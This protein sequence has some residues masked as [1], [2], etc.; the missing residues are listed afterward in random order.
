MFA[1]LPQLAHGGVK[2]LNL[3]SFYKPLLDRTDFRVQLALAMSLLCFLIVATLAIGASVV[4]EREARGATSEGLVGLAA[5]LADRLARGADQRAGMVEVLARIE[6][7]KPVLA[8]DPPAAR[9]LLEQTL[10]SIQGG[11]WF[12]FASADGTVTVAAEGSRE[13]FSAG[14]RSW[15]EH[16]LQGTIV[17]QADELSYSLSGLAPDGEPYPIID[18][19]SPVRDA[20]GKPV[21]V[22]AFSLNWLWAANLRQQTLN[23]SSQWQT[24]EL[25]I[26]SRDGRMIVGPSIGS[27]PYSDAVLA[28]MLDQN[29]GSFSD[30]SKKDRMLT[31]FAVMQDRPSLGW[32]VIARQPEAIA[33]A[34]AH[35]VV[36]VI[37][38]LGLLT[39]ML[40]IVASLYLANRVSQPIMKLAHEADL[41]ERHS[42]EMLPRVRGS[43]EVVRLSSAL[44]ALILRIGFAEERTAAAELRAADAATRLSDDI[45]RLRNLADTDTLTKLLNRRRFLDLAYEAMDGFRETG[46]GFGILMIDVDRFKS[47]NDRFGHPAGDRA[48]QWVAAKIIGS[49]RPNDLAARFGGEEFIVLVA[50]ISMEGAEELAERIRLSI[51]SE[52][53]T[54]VGDDLQITVSIGVALTEKSDVDVE[55]LIGRADLGLYRAKATGRN[56]V[57]AVAGGTPARRV[58]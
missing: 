58:A 24:K 44:R 1:R 21:G 3:G 12:R 20:N 36:S 41:I 32:I 47:V 40:G 54:G 2:V 49:V 43:R 18:L 5:T 35:H 27:K 4:G 14:G 50:E 15:F 16:G 33:F 9:K 34:T 57:V 17:E 8:G 48:I 26:L 11:R 29:R 45:A 28:Q 7:I 37:L 51:A 38:I 23:R 53:L 13:G 46:R 30:G 10:A 56:A 42:V 31:G 25:W 52:P 22:L 19:A 55:E 39:A 6:A